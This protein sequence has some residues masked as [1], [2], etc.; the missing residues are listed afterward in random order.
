[1]GGSSNLLRTASGKGKALRGGM[2]SVRRESASLSR[3]SFSPLAPEGEGKKPARRGENSPAGK[4]NSVARKE[5]TFSH[6]M[7]HLKRGSLRRKKKRIR[8]DLTSGNG[9]TDARSP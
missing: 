4:K 8:K 7:T 1:L 5:K 2:S 6:G 9:G 3:K